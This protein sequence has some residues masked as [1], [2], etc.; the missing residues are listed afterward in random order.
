MNREL[1]K[2][3]EDR[4]SMMATKGWKDLMEDLDKMLA[5]TNNLNG[6]EDEKQLWFKK[7]EL[8]ILYWLKNLKDASSEV[9]EDLQAE[10]NNNA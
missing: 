8:S 4:F 10:E 9:Y 2:Y 7:G 1:Q 5:A 3:Y 6:V